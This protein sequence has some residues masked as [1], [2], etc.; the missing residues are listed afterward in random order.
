VPTESSGRNPQAGQGGAGS[1]AK[2][3]QGR[4]DNQRTGKNPANQTVAD[5]MRL[6]DRE[7]HMT[8]QEWSRTC[9]RINRRVNNA[10]V[11]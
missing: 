8:K 5:C 10:E 3:V 9:R 7:T 1:S 11:R 2:S 6:W 4:T